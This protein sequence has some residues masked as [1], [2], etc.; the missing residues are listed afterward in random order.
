M[1]A[2]IGFFA[3]VLLAIGLVT[4]NSPDETL[5]GFGGAS[6]RSGLF[7]AIWWLAYPQAELPRWLAVACGVTLLVVMYPAEVVAAGH[8]AAGRA[9]VSGACG[10][11]ANRR[12][13]KD[14]RH[15]FVRRGS[16]ERSSSGRTQAEKTGT[17]DSRAQNRRFNVM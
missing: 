5:Y 13:G 16:S 14:E 2:A 3:I 11:A 17:P 9:V 12:A 1:R 7:M 4:R 6:L 10:G 15:M 8:S